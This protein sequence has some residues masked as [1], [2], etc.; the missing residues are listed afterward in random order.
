M[1]WA[2]HYLSTMASPPVSPVQHQPVV[3]GPKVPKRRPQM[4]SAV[5][6]PTDWEKEFLE[7]NRDELY[8]LLLVSFV[9]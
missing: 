8:D 7:K 3:I 1:G 2:D 6:T 9:M 4:P 5:V